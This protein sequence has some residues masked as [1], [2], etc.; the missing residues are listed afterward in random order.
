MCISEIDVE[1]KTIVAKSHAVH[2]HTIR[3]SCIS[4]PGDMA[5][6]SLKVLFLGDL[7]RGNKSIV[8]RIVHN[9]F[10]ARKGSI[11]RDEFD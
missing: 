1:N 10:K 6:L 8:E 4:S 2:L 9:T 3:P 11:V 5:E 7:G